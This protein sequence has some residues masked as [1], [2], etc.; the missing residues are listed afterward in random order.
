MQLQGFYKELHEKL[1]KG[2]GG[3]VPN[4]NRGFW[5]FWWNGNCKKYYFQIEKVNGDY[6]LSIKISLGKT[7]EE[8]LDCNTANV[9][10][11]KKMF[12][13]IRDVFQKEINIIFESPSK[14]AN[15][16]TMTIAVLKDW[17]KLTE[18][19]TIDMN[20]TVRFLKNLSSINPFLIE[21]KTMH[22]S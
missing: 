6:Q 7:I 3:Y 15:G 14:F 2:D 5:G 16:Q 1:G 11:R 13:K 17:Y 12:R 10:C 4:P 21:E 18:D 8:L 22:N 9:N 19:N 20:G